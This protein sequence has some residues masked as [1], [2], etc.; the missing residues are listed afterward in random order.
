M[1]FVDVASQLAAAEPAHVDPFGHQLH[2]GSDRDRQWQLAAVSLQSNMLTSDAGFYQGLIGAHKLH[3]Q[4]H[5]VR[6]GLADK[7]AISLVS[8]AL[9]GPCARPLSVRLCRTAN[10]SEAIPQ[11]TDPARCLSGPQD[12]IIELI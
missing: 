4:D 2:I 6:L 3:E 7:G 5:I 11:L 9:S 1:E 12:E 10:R 8:S